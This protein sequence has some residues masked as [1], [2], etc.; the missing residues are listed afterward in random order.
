M[1]GIIPEE[2]FLIWETATRQKFP[3]R[4]VFYDPMLNRIFLLYYN[5]ETG[6]MADY[7]VLSEGQCDDGCELIFRFSALEKG[8]FQNITTIDEFQERAAELTESDLPRMN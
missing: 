3:D 1:A 7:Y 4:A 8:Y 6:Q 5:E 2:E